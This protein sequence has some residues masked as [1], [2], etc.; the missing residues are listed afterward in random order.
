MILQHPKVRL[1][2]DLTQM[3]KYIYRIMVVEKIAETC[4]DVLF[5][6]VI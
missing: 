1:S 6:P 2:S 3:D 5:D 4:L